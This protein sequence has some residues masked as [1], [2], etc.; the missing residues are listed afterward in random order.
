MI[1]DASDLDDLERDEYDGERHE[2]DVCASDRL[3]VVAYV[4]EMGENARGEQA[5]RHQIVHVSIEVESSMNIS[6]LVCV[7]VTRHTHTRTLTRSHESTSR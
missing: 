6:L 1:D 2:A 3:A 4:G 7:C 5:N